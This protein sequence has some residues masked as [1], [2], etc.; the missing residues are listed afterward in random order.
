VKITG[1]RLPQKVSIYLHPSKDEITSRGPFKEHLL[2]EHIISDASYVI[3]GNVTQ[4]QVATGALLS[5]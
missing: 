3:A 4:M 5:L 1:G 2:A